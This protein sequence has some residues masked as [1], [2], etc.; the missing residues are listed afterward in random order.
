MA[1]DA[2]QIDVTWQLRTSWRAAALL[3]RVAQHVATAEGFHTGELSIAVV[4]DT[5]MRRLHAR[6]LGDAASTDV[7][8]FDLGTSRRAGRLD[9]EIVVCA[10]VARRVARR[11]SATL[12][13]AR[14]ELAL[15]VVHGVLHLAGYDDR[16]LR[17]FRR[18]H[19]RED[20]LLMQ[21][22]LGAVFA[23]GGAGASQPARPRRR[24]LGARQCPN[25]VY[26]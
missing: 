10:A 16:T 14:R 21:L 12:A 23:A 3:K 1:R 20:E 11:R 13:E 5:A 24:R 4:G 25:R 19:A 18:M 17:G 2:L 26:A 9:G 15:Y 22:G 7:L 6:H 8:S